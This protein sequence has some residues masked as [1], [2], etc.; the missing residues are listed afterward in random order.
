MKYVFRYFY[1]SIS[2]LFD[3]F[4]FDIFT[5]DVFTFRHFYLST[6]LPFYI[7][8]FDIFP[9]DII[10]F[11]VF[12]VRCFY[13]STFLHFDI[14]TFDIFTFDQSR[15]NRFFF[16]SIFLLRK[17]LLCFVHIQGRTP[18]SFH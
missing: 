12:I 18:S 4:I 8:T 13:R 15:V 1:I 14:F 2:L 3:I 9:F 11:D 17:I 7:F 10:Y 6:F 5:F 16:F